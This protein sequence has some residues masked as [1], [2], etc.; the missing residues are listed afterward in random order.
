ME[1]LDI[2]NILTKSS[3]ASSDNLVGLDATGAPFQMPQA[4]LSLQQQ[5]NTLNSALQGMQ[6]TL[7][8]LQNGYVNDITSID[9]KLNQ[10][11]SALNIANNTEWLSAIN[12]YEGWNNQLIRYRIHNKIC[13]LSIYS[14]RTSTTLT[15]SSIM[16]TPAII[17]PSGTGGQLTIPCVLFNSN[18]NFFKTSI[19]NIGYG[20]C[21]LN[22]WSNLGSFTG[23]LYLSAF[24]SYPV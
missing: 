13:Y 2:K 4:I 17:T 15:S 10:F 12:N 1:N 18:Y 5:V 11:D 19:L 3:P 22:E 23:T 21:I 24:A 20:N 16:Q 8:G 6:T 7:N 14:S 9:N